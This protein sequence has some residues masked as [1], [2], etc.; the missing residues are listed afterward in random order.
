M[1]TSANGQD[2]Q[3]AK[4]GGTEIWTVMQQTSPDSTADE[5]WIPITPTAPIPAPEP[6]EPGTPTP[7]MPGSG[8]PEGS[9]TTTP[10]R[11][12]ETDKPNVPETSTELTEPTTPIK[13]NTTD[14]PAT[15]PSTNQKGSRRES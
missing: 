6:Q 5:L 3:C 9:E 1:R 14:A 7:D 4:V 10:G 13:P 8:E 12:E 11:P 15:D 2:L